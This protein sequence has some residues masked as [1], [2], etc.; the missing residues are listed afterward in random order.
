MALR[1]DPD[2]A[3]TSSTDFTGPVPVQIQKSEQ[4]PTLMHWISVF[5]LNNS[6]WLPDKI[7]FYE[8]VDES[9]NAVQMMDNN[10]LNAITHEKSCIF[11][12]HKRF[13]RNG[14]DERN[15]DIS[16]LF[17]TNNLP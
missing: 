15:V 16:I 11:G 6:G 9:E 3:S 13:I 8:T 5:I 1:R 4:K 17:R 12:S 2:S 14:G 10:A 7:A